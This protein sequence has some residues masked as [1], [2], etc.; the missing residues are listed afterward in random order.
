MCGWVGGWVGG[1][2]GCVSPL[3]CR[4]GNTHTVVRC[5]ALRQVDNY[6]SLAN[7]D[8]WLSQFP[9]V[10]L[11]VGQGMALGAPAT[12][13]SSVAFTG[14]I[15]V[16]FAYPRP[17]PPQPVSCMRAKGPSGVVYGVLHFRG[18]V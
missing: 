17:T 13:F 14:H 6:G 11:V 1:G 15:G 18:R 9:P 10:S 16:K 2:G 12:T 4:C 5:L 7:I 8:S 3:T